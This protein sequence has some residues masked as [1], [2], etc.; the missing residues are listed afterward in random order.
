[1]RE[2][3]NYI[4]IVEHLESGKILHVQKEDIRTLKTLCAFANID[5]PFHRIAKYQV[6]LP[7]LSGLNGN[8]YLVK[9]NGKLFASGLSSRISL[10][11]TYLTWEEIPQEYRRFATLVQF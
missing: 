8:Q 6:A 2:P 7:G 11:D 3:L 4:T 1:M 9:K 10:K 5:V